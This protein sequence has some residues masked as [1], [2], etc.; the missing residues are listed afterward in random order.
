MEYEILKSDELYHWGI[1]GQ[2]WGV[3]R[4]Q[5]KD[6][7]LTPAGKKRLKK[8]SEA[9]KKEAAILKN[10]KSTKSKIERLEAKRKSIEEQKKALDDADKKKTESN[11]PAKKSISE[12][13][14]DELT[15]AIN[16]ARME[17]AYRQLR[18]EPKAPEK[19]AFAKQLINDAVKPA[20]VNS[21]KK[22][23][24]QSMSNV[25][26]KLTKGKVD[27]NSLEALKSTYEKLDYKHKIDKLLNPD[28]Y[29][30]EEDKTKR[31][32]RGYKAED[33]AAQMEGYKD[34]A[35]KAAKT[36]AAAEASN[37]AQA[38]AAAAAAN[39][40]KSEEY[41]NSTYSTRGGERSTFGS[42]ETSG[43]SLATRY[44]NSPSNGL[45]TTS[46]ISNG[47]SH[48]NNLLDGPVVRIKPDGKLM[49]YDEDG[50]FIGYWSD[51]SGDVD[52][53]I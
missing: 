50:N 31:A 11:K 36:R 5:N 10:R 17:D 45:T 6:G 27:P 39:R 29:L 34:A 25:I 13:S 44:L 48:I 19:N 12:M 40:A 23:L 42:S 51:R 38:D 22:L 18:P 26:E 37:K 3:R 46:N 49:T 15:R 7:S 8:E 47:K 1:K 30:S 24:E 16:R 14:D 52:G 9:L 4:Y 28:K 53:I 41:Y 21:G 20:L 32:D 43:Q 33:R 2:K 35:D